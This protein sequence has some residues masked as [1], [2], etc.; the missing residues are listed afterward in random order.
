MAGGGATWK[1]LGL[2]SAIGAAVVAKKV[3]NTGWEK[4]TGDAP[5]ANP[6]SPDTTWQEALLFA[7]VSGAVV[8]VARMLATRKA[9]DYFRRSTGHLPP[10][11]EEV[12]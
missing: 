1:V 2:G 3:L 5:P 9:A 10:G 11:L 7:V 8:G 6:E 12:T 4:V